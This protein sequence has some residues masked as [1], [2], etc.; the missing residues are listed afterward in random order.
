MANQQLRACVKSVVMACAVASALSMVSG[1]ARAVSL[2][3]LISTQGSI[4]IGDKQFSNFRYTANGFT[5]DLTGSVW[6][7]TEADY[8]AQARLVTVT[9][10]IQ[11]GNY[12]LDFMSNWHAENGVEASFGIDYAVT[13]LD[14]NKYLSDF[15]LDGS[16]SGTGNGHVN[17]L[18]TVSDSVGHSLIPTTPPGSL[19]IYFHSPNELQ[20][21]DF[22]LTN[23]GVMPKSAFIETDVTFSAPLNST[24]SL[25]H[26]QQSFS[27]AVPEPS[28]FVLALC[29]GIGALWM[30]RRRQQAQ[31]DSMA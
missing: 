24:A 27:Q 7:N 19:N 4:T 15:H 16:P 13:V 10:D 29:G 30:S 2:G 14:P 23:A 8:L 25:G 21:N 6:G 9:G 11:D 22:S 26:M 1:Q 17:V 18:E 31:E 12:G 20:Q 5:N 28:T 3:E